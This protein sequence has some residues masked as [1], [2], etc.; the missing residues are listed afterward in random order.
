MPSGFDIRRLPLAPVAAALC[1][2]SAAGGLRA[3]RENPPAAKQ[4]SPRAA[5]AVEIRQLV[6][7]LQA[8]RR[9]QSVAE[10]QHQEDLAR[11]RRQ[12]ETLDGQLGPAEEAVKDQREQIARLEQE[13]A[14][15]EAA[16]NAN[17]AWIARLAKPA[18]EVAA[19]AEQRSLTSAA[20]EPSSRSA[21]FAATAKMLADES[22]SRR[23]DGLK[24]LLRFYSDDWQPAR[25]VGL[26]N[27][28]VILDGGQ[29]SYHA[30]V[31][32]LG[33]VSKSFVAEGGNPMGLWTGQA[34]TPWTL[35]LSA[36]AKE[37]IV[38][39]IDVAREQKAP[40]ILSVPVQTA[41]ATDR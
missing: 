4:Q 12:T 40:M 3:Q 37:R 7:E 6:D 29:R 34:D 16:T 35:D 22:P 30:W 23:A 11:I 36:E 25:T 9:A 10:K 38:L 33:L 27:Q 28:Q 2:L 18:V 14:A 19:R 1:L 15:N 32:R 13:V 8:V 17:R 31:Y 26:S 41:P 20:D 21:A 5:A 39:L 24:D